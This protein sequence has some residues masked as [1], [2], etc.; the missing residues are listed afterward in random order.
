[1]RF[2]FSRGIL[3]SFSPSSFHFHDSEMTVSGTLC[4]IDEQAIA[5]EYPEGGVLA[6]LPSYDTVESIGDRLE[7]PSAVSGKKGEKGNAD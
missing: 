2:H 3:F 7:D 4:A 5:N 6:G 1:L